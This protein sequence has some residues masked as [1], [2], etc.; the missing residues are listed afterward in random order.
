MDIQPRTSKA[1]LRIAREKLMR[2]AGTTQ[3][4]WL[5]RLIARNVKQ[6]DTYKGGRES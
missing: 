5:L 1:E 4:E 3:N 2:K 6:I